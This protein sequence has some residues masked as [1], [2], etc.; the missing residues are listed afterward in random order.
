MLKDR[1]DGLDV[2]VRD[3]GV[4]LVTLVGRDRWNSVDNAIHEALN[5]IWSDLDDD[6]GVRVTV[7]T[8]EGEVFSAGGNLREWEASL[9][10]PSSAQTTFAFATGLIE[11]LV[12]SRKPIISAVNGPAVGVALAVALLADI[13][14]VGESARLGDGHVRIGLPAGDHAAVIWPLLC[15]LAQSKYY[16]LTGELVDG[17]EA[18]RIGLVT[19]CVPNDQVLD[20]ALAVAERLAAGPQAALRTTKRSLNQWLLRAG[21]AFELSAVLETLAMHGDEARE[22]VDAFLQK[23]PPRFT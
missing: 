1:Y 17:H 16:L 11:N 14:I 3:S 10:D 12:R 5:S 2:V 23:R 7:V 20:D 13:S 6:P 18:A 8:G 19:R 15:G 4:A 9:G 22:G 21:P